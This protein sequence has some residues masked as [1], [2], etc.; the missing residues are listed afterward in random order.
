MRTSSRMSWAIRSP[1]ATACQLVVNKLA[2]S[3]RTRE[4]DIRE[5]EENDLERAAVVD[6]N[7]AGA[8]VDRVL[9]GWVW[10]QYEQQTA[11]G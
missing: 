9:S 2:G 3:R 6:V 11:S 8:R 7:D 5:V 10:C 4:V 1:V